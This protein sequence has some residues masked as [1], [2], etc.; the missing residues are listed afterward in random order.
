MADGKTAF[1]IFLSQEEFSED[2]STATLHHVG[3]CL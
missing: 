2:T 3:N 1:V